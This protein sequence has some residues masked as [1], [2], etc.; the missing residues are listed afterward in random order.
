MPRHPAHCDT[1][2]PPPRSSPHRR[3]RGLKK[4]EK[5]PCTERRA[6]GGGGRSAHGPARESGTGKPAA[7]TRRGALAAASAQTGRKLTVQATP[8][9]AGVTGTCTEKGA[10]VPDQLE[11]RVQNG[12]SHVRENRRLGRRSAGEARA[13]ETLLPAGD[14]PGEQPGRGRSL[15]T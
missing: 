2:S 8:K 4:R 1:P 9:G 14:C 5:A 3:E 6:A 12:N 7:A 11:R 13:S 10:T 15:D